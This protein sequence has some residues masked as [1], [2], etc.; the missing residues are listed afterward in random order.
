MKIICEH[1]NSN[2]ALPDEK[3]P[4]GKRVNLRCPKCTNVITVGSHPVAQAQQTSQQQQAH[5]QPASA[6]AGMGQTVREEGFDLDLLEQDGQLAIVMP[7]DTGVGQQL[8]TSVE[9]LG[10]RYVEVSDTDEAIERLRFHHFDLVIFC[11]GFDNQKITKNPVFDYLNNLSMSVRRRMF[12]AVIGSNLKTMN[13]IHAYSLSANVVVSIKDIAKITP[14]LKRTMA[15]NER[16]YKVFM[17]TL[18][19]VGRL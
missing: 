6:S 7:L 15:E 13:S 18:K 2:F 19:E 10:Y 9:K 16:F 3:I 4:K 17:D 8:K 5:P 14:V 1:C 11:E 12:L